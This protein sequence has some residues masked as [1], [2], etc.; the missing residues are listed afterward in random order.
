MLLCALCVLPCEASFAAK[1]SHHE[2]RIDAIEQ[3]ADL[4]DRVNQILADRV[5]AHRRDRTSCRTRW[6][7]GQEH[8]PQAREKRPVKYRDGLNEWSGVG[9]IPNWLKQEGEDIEAFRVV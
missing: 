8:A 5:E 2:P 9:T 6:S 3:F 4:R 1:G 7:S